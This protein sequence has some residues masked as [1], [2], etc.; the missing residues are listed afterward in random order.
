LKYQ[1]YIDRQNLEVEKFRSLEDKQ[2]P[3]WMD[4]S[5]IHGLRTEA[6]LKLDQIRPRTLGH[7]SRIS[8]VSPA[9]ISMLMVWLKRGKCESEASR[10]TEHPSDSLSNCND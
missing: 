6:K 5:M 3:D 9:D 10:K 7:A 4:Y 8:G 1:G 2:I